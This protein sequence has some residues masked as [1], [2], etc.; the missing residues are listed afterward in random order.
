MAHGWKTE[1][2]GEERCERRE[3]EKRSVQRNDSIY[4]ILREK[5]TDTCAREGG[6]FLSRRTFHSRRRFFRIHER[7]LPVTVDR[8]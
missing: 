8:I 6:Q 4:R 3:R 2:G 1:R 7:V 5:G